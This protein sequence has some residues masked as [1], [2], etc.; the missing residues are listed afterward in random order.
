MRSALR[1]VG[2][3]YLEV[4]LDK[5]QIVAKGWAACG[6]RPPEGERLPRGKPL[7]LLVAK[8]QLDR[9]SGTAC[10]GK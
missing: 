1:Q 2:L 3:R 9:T 8:R 5:G 10:R 4:K 6:S 7:V